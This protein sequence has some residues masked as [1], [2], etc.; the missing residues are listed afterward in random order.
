MHAALLTTLI[1]GFALGIKHA[2]DADH[3]VAVSTIVSQYR[4]PLRATVAGILWGIG[5]TATLLVVGIA[6]IVFRVTL[7]DRLALSM[8]FVVGAVLFGLGMQIVWKQLPT[9]KH[10]HFHDHGNEMHVHEHLHLSRDS[11]PG[12]HHHHPRQHRSLLL[13]MVHGLAGSAALMLLVLGTMRTAAA[14][15]AYIFVFGTGSILG[16]MIISTLIGLPFAF[17]SRRFGSVNN[18]IRFAAGVLSVGLGIFVM[19]EIGFFRGLF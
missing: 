11:D 14:G 8:E 10:A 4:N 12:R 17:S 19:V 16:M 6:V 2:V 5:H 3:V 18:G 1:L 15:I 9:R 7:P 13:G